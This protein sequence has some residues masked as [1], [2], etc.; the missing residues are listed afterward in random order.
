MGLALS[1]GPSVCLPKFQARTTS[2]IRQLDELRFD[3]N[4]P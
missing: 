4:I 2:M 3:L 1:F